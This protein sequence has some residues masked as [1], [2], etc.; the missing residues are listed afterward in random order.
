MRRLLSNDYKFRIAF[1]HFTNFRV[2]GKQRYWNYVQDSITLCQRGCQSGLSLPFL[3]YDPSLNTRHWGLSPH[4]ATNNIPRHPTSFLRLTPRFTLLFLLP[5]R[6]RCF[7]PSISLLPFNRD[8]WK[9]VLMVN[10]KQL[11]WWATSRN[12]NTLKIVGGSRL[13]LHWYSTNG[14]MARRSHLTLHSCCAASR[15]VTRF[16]TNW[17]INKP[18]VQVCTSVI[19]S[20]LCCF[21][22]GHPEINR[23]HAQKY[24][25]SIKN[26]LSYFTIIDTFDGPTSRAGKEIFP[27]CELRTTP[28][29]LVS[30]FHS[31]VGWLST[32]QKSALSLRMSPLPQR[33]GRYWRRLRLFYKSPSPPKHHPLI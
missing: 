19:T 4:A 5:P 16:Q 25:D 23:Q 14:F 26:V 28:P 3:P 33:K 15:S 24:L 10:E 17:N 8:P 27:C 11:V 20:E 2:L 1:W 21:N 29:C 31:W 12:G 30:S 22:I 32:D 18:R 9:E 13:L 6:D 7:L